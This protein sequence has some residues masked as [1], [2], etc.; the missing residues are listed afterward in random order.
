MSNSLQ[1]VF[2]VHLSGELY[3]AKQTFLD[4]SAEFLHGL[5][6]MKINAQRVNFFVLVGFFNL[7]FMGIS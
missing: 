2:S 6:W 7:F 5:F 4:I 1:N 3:D